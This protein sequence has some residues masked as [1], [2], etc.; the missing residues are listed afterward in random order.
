MAVVVFKSA[1][2]DPTCPAMSECGLEPTFVQT[3][4]HVGHCVKGLFHLFAKGH[5]WQYTTDTCCGKDSGTGARSVFISLGDR[6]AQIVSPWTILPLTFDVKASWSRSA[7][8]A[9]MLAV[10][11]VN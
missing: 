3:C 7:M 2:M 4:F 8:L 6:R 10:V 5:F 11:N 9:K 1:S